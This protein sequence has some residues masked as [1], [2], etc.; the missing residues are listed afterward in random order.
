M[1]EKDVEMA[2]ALT[3]VIGSS[4]WEAVGLARA[5]IAWARGASLEDAARVLFEAGPHTLKRST[6]L[7]QRMSV[8]GLEPLFT[9]RE[10]MGSAENPVTKLIPATVTEERFLELLDDLKQ[11]R[12]GLDYS[13]E[14]ET[15]NKLI[16]FTIAEGDR[17]LPVNVKN[18][19]TRFERAAAL[20]GLEPNDCVP[21]PA[22]KAHDAIEKV[23]DLLYAVSVDYTLVSTLGRVLPSLFSPQEQL[24]WQLLNKYQGPQTRS[25]ENA[26]IFT[27]VRR[28][29]PGLRK[30]VARTPFN[31]ISARKAVTIL[32]DNPVR[33][34]G[35]GL[36]A[37]GTGASA[38]VNVHVSINS[39]MKPWS[40][41][42]GRIEDNGVVDIIRAVN[43]RVT[44][45][46]PDPEI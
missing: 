9:R 32:H 13:D 39:D 43:R 22:Y 6:E 27:T 30:E 26:F 15:G 42:A 46:V 37:W 7:V 8:E 29:W 24:V 33:T 25:G 10:R 17:E 21:I 19:G 12:P 23:P 3:S 14:R 5:Y 44:R 34:P 38:E 41:I 40:V 16:D 28:H 35:I 4:K 20:V 18:A 45:E 36:R 1:S 31:V 11:R 2:E